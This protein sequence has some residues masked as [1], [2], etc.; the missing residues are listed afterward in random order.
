M[1]G[2]LP[3]WMLQSQSGYVP[4]IQPASRS[5]AEVWMTSIVERVMMTAHATT[6]TVSSLVWPMGKRGS[7]LR[8]FISATAMTTCKCPASNAMAG[9]CRAGQSSPKQLP[10]KRCPQRSLLCLRALPCCVNSSKPKLWL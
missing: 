8:I 4:C 1:T 9:S 3:G 6:P 10:E 5:A 7:A 2:M